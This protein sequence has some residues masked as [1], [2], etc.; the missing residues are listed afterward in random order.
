[1]IISF[2][3]PVHHVSNLTILKDLNEQKTVFF[4]YSSICLHSSG[5]RGRGPGISFFTISPHVSSLSVL[6]LVSKPTFG[7]QTRLSACA[8]AVLGLHTADG[9]CSP[10]PASARREIRIF[11]AE[12]GFEMSSIP[13]LIPPNPL[14]SSSPH[15]PVCGFMNYT[16]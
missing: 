1:M 7:L 13:F 11:A 5:V 6:E 8:L 12:S 4:L 14:I 2:D 9:V 15:L 3:V 10:R 16:G